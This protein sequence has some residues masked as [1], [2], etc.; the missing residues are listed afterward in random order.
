MLDRPAKPISIIVS[1]TFN[2]KPSETGDHLLDAIAAHCQRIACEAAQMAWASHPK[3]LE[4]MERDTGLKGWRAY[5]QPT[6]AHLVHVLEER[7]IVEFD[8]A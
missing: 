4:F 2:V 3:S 1:E 7:G 6:S 5:L 8:D